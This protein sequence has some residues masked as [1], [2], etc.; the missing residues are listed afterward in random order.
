MVKQFTALM[1]VAIC[2]MSVP[3]L[4][5]A[6]TARDSG[7][8]TVNGAKLWYETEGQGEPL[9]LIAGGPG[10]S[11]TYFK[12]H[13]SVLADSFRVVYF[14][15][16]GRGM[17]DRAKSLSEYT[18]DRDVEDIEGLRT[19]LKLGRVSLLGH[20]YGGVVAQAYAL[21]YPESVNKLILAN[22][23]FSSEVWQALNDNANREIENQ[24]PVIW[25]SLQTLRAQGQRSGSENHQ[26]LYFQVPPSLVYFYDGSKMFA[27]GP[28]DLNPDVYYAMVGDDGDFVLGGT[29]AGFDYRDQLKN[30]EMPTLILAGRYDRVCFPKYSEQFK[31]YAPHAQFVM[32]EQSGHFPFIEE[33]DLTFETLRVFLSSRKQA[34]F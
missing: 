18:V 23:L 1:L 28:P 33:P 30:L 15:A 16:L 24:F 7:Y 12:P 25:D 11:H 6:Q 13:F 3:M 26:E 9:L 32:F 2:V 8:V 14:D 27:L 22:T 4:V 29:L 20:S 21:R 31:K 5:D 34:G 19:Q 17:S 10:I